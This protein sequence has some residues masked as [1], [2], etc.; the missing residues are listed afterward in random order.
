MVKN[1]FILFAEWVGENH[2]HLFNIAEGVYYWKNEHDTKTTEELFD[3]YL[4]EFYI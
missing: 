4:D 2:Y 3:L 1:K